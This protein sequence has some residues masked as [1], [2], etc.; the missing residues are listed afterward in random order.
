MELNN[1]ILGCMIYRK[2]DLVRRGSTELNYN[3]QGCMIS[4]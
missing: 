4:W 2:T 1:N 3:V